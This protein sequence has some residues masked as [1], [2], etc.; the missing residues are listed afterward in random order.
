MRL[1]IRRVPVVVPGYRF[2]GVRCGLKESGKR[3]VAVIAS[4]VPAAA[5]VAFT[6]NRVKAAPVR[7]GIEHAAGGLYHLRWALT[8]RQ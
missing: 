1:S 2:A 6:T 4:D 3:D 5:A 8:V 7:V